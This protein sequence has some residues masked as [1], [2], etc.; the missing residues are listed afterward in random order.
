MIFR[1][2]RPRAVLALS[3]VLAVAAALV[4]QASSS[5]AAP[6]SVTPP[7][8]A[9]HYVTVPADSAPLELTIALTPSSRSQ[10]KA[11]ASRRTNASSTQRA[12][13]VA[14]TEPTSGARAQVR[15]A[16]AKGGFSI[17]SQS[18]WEIKVSATP[19]VVQKFFGVTLIGS[20]TDRRADRAPTLPAAFGGYVTAVLGLD[21]R[22]VFHRRTIPI[23]GSGG[24]VGASPSD[25]RAAY[26]L[27]PADTGTGATVATV[28]FSGWDKNDLT[29]Y[30][31]KVGQTVAAGQ[32]T[33][34]ALDSANPRVP[35]QG[36]DLEVALDQ[37]MLL[38]AA[39]QAKQ[40]AYFA[41][42]SLAGS[43]DLYTKIAS[44]VAPRALTA[45]S[46]SWGFCQSADAPDYGYE[47]AV[48]DVIA[49][50]VASGA[51]AF[52]A[53]GDSGADDCGA[54]GGARDV[55]FPAVLP[56]VVAV[57]GTRLNST[58]NGVTFT[59]TAWNTPPSGNDQGGASGGGYSATTPRPAY[60]TSLSLSGVPTDKRLVPDVSATADYNSSYGPYAYNI[61]VGGDTRVGGT[62]VGAPLM[63]GALAARLT[64]SGCTSGIGD[65]HTAL[66]GNPDA[67]HFRDVTLGNN[68]FPPGS[69]G[70]NAA[71]GYDLVT[72]LGSV[73]WDGF[74]DA[75]LLPG[76]VCPLVVTT[77]YL[78]PNDQANVGQAISSVTLQEAGGT[79]PY[80]WSVLAGS[81][82]PGVNLNSGVV[83][84]TPT[85][86]GSYAVTLQVTDSTA[87]TQRTASRSFTLTV[88]SPAGRFT[89]TAAHRVFDKN[90]STTAYPVSLIG[91][92][93][94][95]TAR[96][97]A[98]NLSVSQSTAAG[99]LRLT[100]YKKD[101]VVSSI[102]YAK[103]QAITNFAVVGL[104]NGAAQI[105][106][107]TGIARVAVDVL[108][109]YA[110][111]AG[112]T[113]TALPQRRVFSKTISTTAYPVGFVP[114]AGVPASAT[115]VVA[116]V[117]IANPSTSGYLRV[118]PYKRDTTVPTLQFTKGV[119]TSNL[120]VAGLVNGA[121]QLKLS[122]GTG[123]AFIDI[124]GYYAPGSGLSFVSMPTTR[125]FT[126]TI[127]ST[128]Q[129]LDFTSSTQIPLTAKAV[130]FNIAI[131]SETANGY[132]K[133]TSYNQAPTV[134]TQQ[135]TARKTVAAFVIVK[136]TGGIADFK[137][138][139][140]TARV[141]LDVAG[142]Y[143]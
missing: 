124:I 113:F 42:N 111:G 17:V 107:N 2:T 25:L 112:S 72:G 98:L 83:S 20:G 13:D 54:G 66:Y 117:G 85:A 30:A 48:S 108:G 95:T 8:K 93:V 71:T 92:G 118:T 11:L 56:Q 51:T 78:A 15:S 140:G 14:K 67:A 69:A 4:V 23:D 91:N 123:L 96:A 109:Y 122:G 31:S 139:A 40:V 127:D 97:V 73:Q 45:M 62:S 22:A 41:P 75:Q 52:A 49:R 90:I 21:Q 46:S 7:S 114:S 84:G 116:N 74:T 143:N 44:D 106:V 121:V 120:V 37:E 115:A 57:G 34:V 135:Y 47:A 81:L 38:A 43:Y 59:E 86:A 9:Q 32:L 89:P 99:Y 3:T 64:P 24:K 79:G 61:G 94:P 104:A 133:I 70:Y 16:L 142:Y 103:G 1:S 138:S 6:L 10:L 27:G 5:A 129:S 141:D 119:A 29:A 88:K 19:A 58:D 105:K 125:L 134:S 28:Q 50:A 126:G 63:A 26:G 102:N 110:D 33:E 87:G 100:P 136:L 65:I 55:D 128:V 35:D 101:A 76:G 36:G 80:T 53:S 77:S 39:P 130:A 68:S 131:S 137:L 12:A 18:A 82:P 60:Q 132:L